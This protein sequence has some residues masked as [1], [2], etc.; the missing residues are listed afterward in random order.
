MNLKTNFFEALKKW[1]GPARPDASEPR[2]MVAGS[3]A[4]DAY[5]TSVPLI[6][7]TMQELSSS[8]NVGHQGVPVKLENDYG[9]QVRNGESVHTVKA[10]Y[11]GPHGNI[12]LF[13]ASSV[14]CLNESCTKYEQK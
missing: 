5:S 7:Q 8:L 2:N 9:H 14:A 11:F 10:P 13:L 1:A 3:Q 12:G 6:D 4:V